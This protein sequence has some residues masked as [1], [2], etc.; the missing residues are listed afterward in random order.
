MVVYGALSERPPQS[1]SFQA[2]PQNNTT[3]RRN[4]GDNE[5][6]VNHKRLQPISYLL[7]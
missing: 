6:S 2:G 3:P 7:E 1:G 4:N 5:L